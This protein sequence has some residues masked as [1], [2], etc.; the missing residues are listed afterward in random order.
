MG[1]HDVMAGIP[2]QWQMGSP[3]A[4][5]GVPVALLSQGSGGNMGLQPMGLPPPPNRPPNQ[6]STKPRFAP[7]PPHAKVGMIHPSWIHF[8]RKFSCKC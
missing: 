6:S 1:H 2:G 3:G 5:Q 7:P 8:G 4:P